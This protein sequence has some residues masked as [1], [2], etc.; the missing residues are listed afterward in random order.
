VKSRPSRE[1][2]GGPPLSTQIYQTLRR[3]IITGELNQ[4]ERLAEQRLAEQLNV[5]RIPL[6]EAIPQLVAEGF[7]ESLPRRGT[8]VAAW[9]PDT[10]HDLFDT[11]LALEPAAAGRAA[12]RVAAGAPTHAL[13][14]AQVVSETAL[15]SA[16]P[17]AMAE[18]NAH[19]HQTL[20]DTAQ[21][22]LM[23]NLMSA[24][25]GRMAWLFYLT[26]QRDFALACQEHAAITDVILS[27]NARLAE[28]EIYSHIEAGRAPSLHALATALDTAHG[29]DAPPTETAQGTNPGNEGGNSSAT[30]TGPDARPT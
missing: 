21:N 4:N 5:S 22:R 18:A 2:G 29:H 13:L 28:A 3:Q 15:A 23:S 1:P 20:V 8:V 24:I 30:V 26:R 19:F 11:R 6:R 9:S 25:S 16:D 10:L 14:Q 17:L 27:G 7:V 12:T